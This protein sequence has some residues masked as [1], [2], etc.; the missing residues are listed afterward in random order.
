MVQIYTCI[1]Y[2]YKCAGVYECNCSGRGVCAAT[3]L[4]LMSYWFLQRPLL[5]HRKEDSWGYE[6]LHWLLTYKQTRIPIYLRRTHHTVPNSFMGS[7]VN[8][9]ISAKVPSS[10]AHKIWHLWAEDGAIFRKAIRIYHRILIFGYN[11][12]G[13][14]SLKCFCRPMHQE[15]FTYIHGRLSGVSRMREPWGK[16]PHR[17]EQNFA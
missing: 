3:L 17:H 12:W 1:L 16:D 11:V 6:I 10:R 4:R 2:V 15:I 5:S 8:I 13:V 14:D 7:P 9:G